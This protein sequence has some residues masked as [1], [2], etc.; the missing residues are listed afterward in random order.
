MAEQFK[1]SGEEVQMELQG[2]QKE[3]G[4]K[5]RKVDAC[6]AR[7]HRGCGVS[8]HKGR[9]AGKCDKMKRARRSVKC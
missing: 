4:G 7:V 2:K 3:A 5:Q 1:G 6:N 9:D 8:L